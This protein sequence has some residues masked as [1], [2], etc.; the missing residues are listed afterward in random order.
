MTGQDRPYAVLAFG[1]LNVDL[2][3][4][5]IAEPPKLGGEVLAEH[6]G[7]HAGGSTANVA[8]C[9]AQL[10]LP[11]ALVSNVGDDSFGDFLVGEM[12]RLGVATTHILRHNT[13]RTGITVSISM[14]HDRAF[15]THVG[16]IDSLTAQDATDDLLRK[17]RHLHVGSYFLQNRL[18]PDLGDVLNRAHEAGTTVSLDTGYDPAEEWDGGLLDLLP[19]VDAFL[20]NETE[21]AG[22]TGQADPP[23]ALRELSRHCTVAVV[24]LGPQGAIAAGDGETFECPGLK[25]EVADTTCCG[26]AFNAGFLQEW[27]AGKGIEECLRMGNAC[28]ALVATEPGNSAHLLS[29]GRP[30][31]LLGH[32]GGACG[33]E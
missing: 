17:T 25:V 15:V 26:D 3:L 19:L 2:I 13:L 20:P 29:G 11:T 23:A 33:P 4:S 8:A 9:C 28:G 21:A 7:M 31:R 24:K 1:E 16:T 18:R 32:R 22:I 30:R 12:E 27:L 14:P 6:L 10:G 5:G